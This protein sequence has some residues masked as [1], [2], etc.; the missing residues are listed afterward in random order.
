[1]SELVVSENV[2]NEVSESLNCKKE[3]IIAVLEMLSD[4]KTVAFIARY[5]KEATGG[6][7]E[8]VIRKISDEYNYGINL[9]KRKADVIR[10]IEE[11]GMKQMSDDSALLEIITK[12]L[13]NSPKQIEDYKNGKTNLI[14]FFVGQVMKETRGTA[15]P[16][17]VNKI[18]IEEIN[19]R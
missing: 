9:E 5:R 11:K 4:D 3:H 8:E 7:D 16:G 15:N 6:L 12:I 17:M 19:K 14:G 13:D 18:L 10:L 2:I 1:M